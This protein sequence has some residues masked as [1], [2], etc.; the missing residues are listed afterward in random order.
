MRK[1]LLILTLLLIVVTSVQLWMTKDKTDQK[2]TVENVET[3]QQ[4]QV[5]GDF[6]LT[7]QN[8]KPARDTDFRGR[9]MLVFFGFTHCPDICPV[10]VASLSKMMELLGDKA[11]QVAPIFI[12]VDPKRD[13]PD[14]MKAYLANFDKRIVGLT[15]TDEQIR[16]AAATYKAYYA[17]SAKPEQEE[18]GEHG[19]H[20]EAG[21]SEY[22]VD[23]SGYIY[24]MG[25]D[26]KF[27]QVFPY[28]VAAT[29]L[30]AALKPYVN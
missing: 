28:N 8:G 14:V 22:N 30:V 26:G 4:A 21:K 5:G 3:T 16:Q 1:F 18:H 17:K 9:A 15:G 2:Q 13:T 20:D 11:D 27:I 12:T 19:A 24:L 10:S 25:K 29:D 6:A 7:D 23:H